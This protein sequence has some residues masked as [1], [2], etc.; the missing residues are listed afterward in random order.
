MA[1]FHASSTVLGDGNDQNN[2]SQG[3]NSQTNHSHGGKGQTK[4]SQHGKGQTKYALG[5]KPKITAKMT[6]TLGSFH[7]AI[8]IYYPQ[9]K[10]THC[11]NS[12]L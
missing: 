1:D 9:T 12:G 3:G 2:H 4:C 7:D 11:G 8:K 10:P 5:T 6:E